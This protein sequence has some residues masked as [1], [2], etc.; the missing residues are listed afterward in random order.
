[1][2][3]LEDWT[4]Q[5]KSVFLNSQFTA[6]H[7]YYHQ[8]YPNAR[9]DIIVR[10]GT[11]IGRLYV[12]DIPDELILMDITLLDAARNAG[13]G[14]QLVSNLLDEA[15]RKQKIVS[16]HV[17]DEKPGAAPVRSTGLC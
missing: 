12:A 4:A 13:L 15:E 3:L 9:Y 17:E 7:R 16:L 2:A 14:T 6:Q 8:H 1:M 5:Q 11:P 10:D